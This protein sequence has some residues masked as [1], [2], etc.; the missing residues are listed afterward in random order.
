MN[1]FRSKIN[2]I[3]PWI[4]K[5]WTDEFYKENAWKPIFFSGEDAFQTAIYEI[6]MK[7]DEE[8]NDLIDKIVNELV[9]SIINKDI[10][11]GY[12]LLEQVIDNIWENHVHK[13]KLELKVE[14][15]KE[16]KQMM[17]YNTFNHYLTDIYHE[18]TQLP[19]TLIDQIVNSIEVSDYHHGTLNFDIF[20]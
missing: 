7:F 6:S 5:S 18:L 11:K 9:I 2:R 16:V 10:W 1:E 4:K 19:T 8:K 3:L 20:G 12:P 13:I 15:E 14:Y 17:N